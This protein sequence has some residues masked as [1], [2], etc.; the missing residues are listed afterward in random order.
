[1]ITPAFGAATVR[2]D[3]RIAAMCPDGSFAFN[4]QYNYPGPEAPVSFADM[5]AVVA[6]AAA[7]TKILLAMGGQNMLMVTFQAGNPES[8][9]LMVRF[10]AMDE[11]YR[12]LRADPNLAHVCAKNCADP[13]DRWRLWWRHEVFGEYP[14]EEKALAYRSTS[15][16]RL[17]VTPPRD[18]NFYHLIAFILALL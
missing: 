18:T 15:N 16:L 8:P 5:Q 7:R 10:A 11:N 4:D 1:M 12:M 17:S 14:T 6:E 2:V 9:P 13:S 3:V